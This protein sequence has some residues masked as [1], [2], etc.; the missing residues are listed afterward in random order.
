MGIFEM[1]RMNA[2]MR[3]MTFKREPT[4][5]I[6]RQARLLGMR[7]LLE[8]GVDKALKGITTLEEVLSTC[9]HES[10]AVTAA[11]TW[12]DAHVPDSG[13]RSSVSR[14]LSSLSSGSDRRADAGHATIGRLTPALAGTNM[15]RGS[16]QV[17]ES[18]RRR[19]KQGRGTS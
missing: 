11:S 4:Q 19:W 8:D 5:N 2:A 16:A 3:E 15:P 9:H 7:T 6:R 18:V 14:P 10:I 12:R 17:G 13:E 1:L